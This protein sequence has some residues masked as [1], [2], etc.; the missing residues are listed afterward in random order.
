MNRPL[1]FEKAVLVYQSG[2]ANVFAVKDWGLSAKDSDGQW[3]YRERL[4]QADFRTC[5]AFTRGLESAGVDIMSVHSNTAGNADMQ[6]WSKDLDHAPFR[7]S[8]H[9]VGMRVIA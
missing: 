4:V 1:K 8:M 3:A 2:I 7:E 6:D 5:E 9:P